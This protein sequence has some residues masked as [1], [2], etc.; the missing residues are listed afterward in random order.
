MQQEAERRVGDYMAA[1]RRRESQDGPRVSAALDRAYALARSAGEREDRPVPRRKGARGALG[2]ARQLL[3][4]GTS[5]VLLVLTA[6]LLFWL[7]TRAFQPV[8]ALSATMDRFA[9]RRS[10]RARGGVGPGE[11][12]A[13]ARRFN[14]LAD[15]IAAQRDAQMAFLAGVAHD[16]RNPLSAIKLS[17]GDDPPRCAAAAGA[18]ACGAR[19]SCSTAS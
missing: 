3:G 15:A 16:L 10:Q 12:R 19:C 18:A 14:D 8:T 4:I 1:A 5:A 7:W 9:A 2:H 13:M 17:V 11:L 6:W